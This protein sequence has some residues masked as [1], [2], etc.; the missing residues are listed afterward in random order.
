V[1]CMGAFGNVVQGNLI[2]GN[3]DHGVGIGDKGSSYNAILGNR[4]GTDANGARAVPNGGHGVFF[5]ATHSGST[6]SEEFAPRTETSSAVIARAESASRPAETW[7]W[8]TS[9]EPT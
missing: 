2:S 8:A 7:S 6:G 3:L 9:W 4:I 1:I 5:M